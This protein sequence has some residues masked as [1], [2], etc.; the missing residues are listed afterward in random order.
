MS[1]FLDSDVP[2]DVLAKA[3]RGDAAAQEAIYRAF[4]RP[5]RALARRLVPGAAAAA[6][7]AQDVFVEVLTRL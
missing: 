7:V 2:A 6:D 4:E 5:V 1:A 3:R